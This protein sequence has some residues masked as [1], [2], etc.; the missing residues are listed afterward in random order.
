MGGGNLV[1]TT[2]ALAATVNVAL[3]ACLV[4]AVRR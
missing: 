3:C 2:L 1:L 4:V